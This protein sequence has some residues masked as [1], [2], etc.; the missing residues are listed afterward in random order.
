MKPSNG[1][2]E[3]YFYVEDSES[4]EADTDH[5]SKILDAKY[6]PADLHMVTTSMT[7]LMQT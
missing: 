5:I 2:P 6:E 1:T 7:E 3:H 4:I